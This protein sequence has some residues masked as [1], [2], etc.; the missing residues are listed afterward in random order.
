M[1]AAIAARPV[2]AVRL[3]LVLALV[4]LASGCALLDKVGLPGFSPAEV[5]T[6]TVA[7]GPAEAQ[8]VVRTARQLAG[9]PYR[10]GGDSPAT[11]FDCSGLA[12]WAFRQQGLEIPRTA[13]EQYESG[14]CV[15]K[16]DL[17]PGDLVFFKLGK[18]AKGL[19]VGIVTGRGSFIHSPREGG[20]VREDD[21]LLPYWQARFVGARRYIG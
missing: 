16:A 4:F 17:A 15:A 18:R 1:N 5:R 14:R 19:H 6:Q 9:Q 21:L 2:P 13:A 10:Y 11:G 3:I 20:R 8:G 7:G 12:W